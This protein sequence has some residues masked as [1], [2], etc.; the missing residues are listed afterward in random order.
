MAIAYDKGWGNGA[1]TIPGDSPADP[2]VRALD[3]AQSLIQQHYRSLTRVYQQLRSTHKS[4][5]SRLHDVERRLLAVV[6][7]RDQPIFARAPRRISRAAAT[8]VVDSDQ[9]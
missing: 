3:D 6:E 4:Y 5:L 8:A 2:L 1:A 7:H 9:I